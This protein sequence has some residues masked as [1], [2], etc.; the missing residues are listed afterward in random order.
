MTTSPC[1]PPAASAHEVMAVPVAD[2]PPTTLALCW[3]PRAARPQILSFAR[4]LKRGAADRGAAD[5][6]GTPR[7]RQVAP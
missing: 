7:L 2:L 3:L 1:F 4:S 6:G 5:R